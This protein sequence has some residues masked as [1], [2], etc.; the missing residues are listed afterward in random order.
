MLAAPAVKL[1][2]AGT[3]PADITPRMVDDGAVGVRQ[4]HA[5]RLAFAGEQRRRTSR[6]ARAA[7]VSSL[8]IAERAG[9][10]DP[11]RRRVPMPCASAASMIASSTVRVGIGG[12]EHQVRHDL[13]ER[14][15]R[16]R[17]ALAALEF[18]R[19]LRAS[20]APGW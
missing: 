7:P 5:E 18:W 1:I 10:S 20:P 12:A 17:A 14:G 15:A 6:R 8:L 9:D 16:G 2:I 3:W 19:R 11:R 13:V 4:H